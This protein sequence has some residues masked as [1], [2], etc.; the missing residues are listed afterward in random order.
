MIRRLLIC[1]FLLGAQVLLGPVVLAG[2]GPAV[3]GK[4]DEEQKLDLP[5]ETTALSVIFNRL[6]A[7]KPGVREA[8]LQWLLR[9][10][11]ALALGYFQRESLRFDIQEVRKTT[12]GGIE[13]RLVECIYTS[14]QAM[15][16]GPAVYR[17]KWPVAYLFDDLGRLRDWVN[18]YD[19]LFFEDLTADGRLELFYF[20]DSL[21]RVFMVS[22]GRGRSRELLRVDDMPRRMGVPIRILP[23]PKDKPRQVFVATHGVFKWDDKA[24]RYIKAS[25][26][27]GAEPGEPSPRKEGR[28]T[29]FLISPDGKRLAY[30]VPVFHRGGEEALA[31][32]VCHLDGTQAKTVRTVPGSGHEILWFGND[33][34]ITTTGKAKRYTI[35]PVDGSETSE[36]TIPKDCDISQKRLSP[37]G[38]RVAFRGRFLMPGEGWRHGLYVLTWETGQV[39]RLLETAVKS[40]PAW[41]PDSRKIAMGNA[42]GY[43]SRYPLVIVDVETGKVTE[44]GLQGV[45]ASWSSDG[46][47]LAFTTEIVRGGSWV[48]GIPADGR[49]GVLDVE[50]GKLTHLSPP[51]KNVSDRATG[52]WEYEGYIHPVWAPGEPRLAFHRIH[53]VRMGGESTTSHETWIASLDGTPARKIADEYDALAWGLDGKALFRLGEKRIDRIDLASSMVRTLV[54]WKDPERPV[55]T[56]EDTVVIENPGVTVKITWIDRAYGEAFS[57]I[58]REA[59][60][61]FEKG[62]GLSLPDRM[63]LEVTKD[64]Q[65]RRPRLWTDG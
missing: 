29:S 20:E 3:P 38:K 31:L 62:L 16:S 59:R 57:R 7:E 4:G 53:S 27:A 43:R 41:S 21:K 34:L 9:R 39:R 15:I 64:P 36:L 32:T 54:S 11:K 61:E 17:A 24:K 44:T 48:R 10:E 50:T 49:I 13:W 47:F 8:A 60:V 22:H 28:K 35:I 52:R 19:V 30:G 63:I 33:R 5:P 42:P 14:K 1:A 55:P 6:E 23:G 45:G 2:E 51:G 26:L 37:D 40:P 25:P 58:L 46:R 56:A 65:R 18:D 12:A